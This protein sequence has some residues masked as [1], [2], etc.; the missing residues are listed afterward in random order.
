M[1]LLQLTRDGGF[2]GYRYEDFEGRSVTHYRSM[3]RGF[4]CLQTRAERESVAVAS[5]FSSLHGVSSTF[6]CLNTRRHVAQTAML[7]TFA[8]SRSIKMPD[9]GR[10]EG[11]AGVAPEEA[12]LVRHQGEDSPRFSTVVTFIM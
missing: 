8:V 1:F 4:A 10:S 7:F 5:N 9:D 2:L 11:M 12:G 3:A 6:S